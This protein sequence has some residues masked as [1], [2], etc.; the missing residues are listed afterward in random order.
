VEEEKEVELDEQQEKVTAEFCNICELL[1][2][3]CNA[4]LARSVA[5]AD[6]FVF[7]FVLHENASHLRVVSNEKEED[8]VGGCMV[9]ILQDAK[10]G[11]IIICTDASNHL[12]PALLATGCDYGWTVASGPKVRVSLGSSFTGPKWCC[13]LEKQYIPG[14]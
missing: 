5:E 7:Q 14:I 9:G 1:T 10:A 13:F 3:S 8:R 12:W 2:A 4:A 11:A 6:L